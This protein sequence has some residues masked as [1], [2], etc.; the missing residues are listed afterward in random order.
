MF[1]FIFYKYVLLKTLRGSFQ[2]EFIMLGVEN[3]FHCVYAQTMCLQR[4]IQQT[5]A[6]S[7]H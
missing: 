6:A 7:K 3:V 4:N 5:T 1:F 2:S